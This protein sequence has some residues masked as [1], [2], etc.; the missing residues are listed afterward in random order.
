MGYMGEWR[1]DGVMQSILIVKIVDGERV[2]SQPSK[3]KAA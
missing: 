2:F 1:G 3:P